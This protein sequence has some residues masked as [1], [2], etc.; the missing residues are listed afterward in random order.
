MGI[1]TIRKKSILQ[2]TWENWLTEALGTTWSFQS[3]V[4]IIIIYIYTLGHVGRAQAPFPNQIWLKPFITPWNI[5][6]ETGNHERLYFHSIPASE[7]NKNPFDPLHR[8]HWL[9]QVVCIKPRHR[10][11]SSSSLYQRDST[12]E[13]WSDMAAWIFGLTILRAKWQEFC[14]YTLVL[15]P[16]ILSRLFLFFL[17]CWV[18]AIR[19]PTTIIVTYSCPV[20][21]FWSMP[22]ISRSMARKSMPATSTPGW[23]ILGERWWLSRQSQDWDVHRGYS[24]GVIWMLGLT[25]KVST[26]PLIYRCSL[27]TELLLLRSTND[28]CMYHGMKLFSSCILVVCMCCQGATT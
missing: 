11:W 14:W 21:M 1:K 23:E 24:I 26:V 16:L 5:D 4:Y 8:C 27:A 25:F 9:W 28:A 10:L 7:E 18:F 3:A 2:K 20:A 22:E 13:S 15:F 17:L 6:M 19:I 12:E